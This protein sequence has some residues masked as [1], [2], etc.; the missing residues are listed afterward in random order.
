MNAAQTPVPLELTID[1]KINDVNGTTISHHD[2][3]GFNYIGNATAISPKKF[4]LKNGKG[5]TISGSTLK[6]DVPALSI[7]V[8]ELSSK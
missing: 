5:T 2:E 3:Y 1:F 8:L 7:T 6:W 4:D